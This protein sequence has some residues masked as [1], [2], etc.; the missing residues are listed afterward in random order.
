MT[1]I[2]HWL[3]AILAG[4]RGQDMVEYALITVL[5]SVAILLAVFAV[6][7]GAFTTW[8]TAVGSCVANPLANC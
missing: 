2:Q 8:A 5:V 4:E 7:P 3:K 6:L 1:R